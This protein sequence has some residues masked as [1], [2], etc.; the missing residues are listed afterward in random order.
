MRISPPPP[1]PFVPNL[2]GL[3][4]VVLSLSGIG[5]IILHERDHRRESTSSL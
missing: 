3:F 1:L 5:V 2:L 4:G